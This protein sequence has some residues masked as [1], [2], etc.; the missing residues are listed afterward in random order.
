MTIRS[1]FS[2]TGR[3]VLEDRATV[4]TGTARGRRSGTTRCSSP[5]A[6]FTMPAPPEMLEVLER[7]AVDVRPH[8]AEAWPLR[9]N[10]GGRE[11][12]GAPVR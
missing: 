1:G 11:N 2:L 9:P 4:T 3:G 6:C 5:T 10:G 7:V 8:V 12:G